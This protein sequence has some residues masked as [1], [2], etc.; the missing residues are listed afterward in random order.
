MITDRDLWS[1]CVAV[2][3]TTTAAASITFLDRLNYL[4]RGFLCVIHGAARG[5]DTWPPSGRR[6][7]AYPRCRSDPARGLGST[8]PPGRA[9]PER[10]DDPRGQPDVVIAFP[11]GPGTR[12]IARQAHAHGIVVLPKERR[13]DRAKNPA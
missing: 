6:R 12:N 8:R 2:V 1:W 5:A 3:T 13:Q 9:D 7:A 10:A 4:Y 11:G